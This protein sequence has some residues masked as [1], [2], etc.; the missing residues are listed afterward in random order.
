MTTELL[1]GTAVWFVMRQQ[2]L[3]LEDRAAGIKACKLRLKN[4]LC[5]AI[6]RRYVLSAHEEA[7]LARVERDFKGFI[8]QH[9]RNVG[10]FAALCNSVV[11]LPRFGCATCRAR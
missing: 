1:A 6:R 4:R 8:R 10:D 3:V 7:Q 11:A 9:R 5:E 2:L